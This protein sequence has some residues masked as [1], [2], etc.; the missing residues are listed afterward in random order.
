[1]ANPAPL[2]H[3]RATMLAVHLGWIVTVAALATVWIDHLTAN[4][5][6]EHIRVS[7]PHYNE[8]RVD[9]AATTYLVYLSVVG[10]IGLIGWLFTIWALTRNKPWIRPAANAIFVLAT[11]LLLMNLLIRDTSGDTGLPAQLGWVGLA[12]SLPGLVAVI[13]LRKNRR[14]AGA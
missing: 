11:G 4:V 13:L 7:Y 3:Q 14:A 5:L 2:T 10:V 9:W 12:P 8:A 6:A 1:M